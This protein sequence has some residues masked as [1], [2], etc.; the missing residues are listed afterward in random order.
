MLFYQYTIN[1]VK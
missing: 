1:L